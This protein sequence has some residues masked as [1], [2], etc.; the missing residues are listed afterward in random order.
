VLFFITKSNWKK[1]RFLVNFFINIKYRVCGNYPIP[2]APN[3][4]DLCPLFTI[5]F[6][7]NIYTS[8]SWCLFKT[9]VRSFKMTQRSRR[10]VF[11]SKVMA[12]KVSRYNYRGYTKK[13][14][15]NFFEHPVEKVRFPLR[16]KIFAGTCVQSAVTTNFYFF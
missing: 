8:R 12:K 2:Y 10:M 4:P 11:L 1:I 14:S 16:P 5:T 13:S 6:V 7:R 15:R 9:H 3:K